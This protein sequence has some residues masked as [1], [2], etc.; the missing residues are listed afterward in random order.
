MQ[1]RD[2]PYIAEEFSLLNKRNNEDTVAESGCWCD[3]IGGR[4][5]W[6]MNCG[7]VQ[8]LTEVR[9][10]P[11]RRK[12]RTKRERD[13]MY[14]KHLR[15]CAEYYKGYPPCVI[16][17]DKYGLAVKAFGYNKMIAYY[18]RLY[19]SDINRASRFYKRMAN[20]VVRRYKGE[21]HNGA[22]YKKCFEYWYHIC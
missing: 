10:Y 20:R 13:A 19:R 9:K 21:L 16:P 11:T 7:D 8:P 12:R 4:M 6:Y 14:K 17:V 15:Y 18:K 1:C 5:L 2:C 22:A 3:K